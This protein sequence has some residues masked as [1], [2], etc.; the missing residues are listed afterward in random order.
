MRVHLDRRLRRLVRVDDIPA[1]DADLNDPVLLHIR[2]LPGSDHGPLIDR[3][4]LRL[5]G[6]QSAPAWRSYL[7]LAFI[8][9]AAKAANGRHRIYATRPKVKRGRGRGATRPGRQTHTEA[10]RRPRERLERPAGGDAVRGRR[11]PDTGAQP[12]GGPRTRP[13]PR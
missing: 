2:H 7:R 6:L 13:E 5:F 1:D 8:W 9:D 11:C 12:P 4:R 3:Q 10:W